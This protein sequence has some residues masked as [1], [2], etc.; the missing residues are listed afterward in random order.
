[1]VGGFVIY[2][3]LFF[4][5]LLYFLNYIVY[6]SFWQNSETIQKC[7]LNIDKWKSTADL[8]S[9]NLSSA[10]KI[11]M[12]HYLLKRGDKP[13]RL[14]DNLYKGDAFC[15]FLFAFLHIKPFLK[16]KKILLEAE[17]NICSLGSK[18]FP[19]IKGTFSH[20]ENMPMYF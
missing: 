13:C 18:V 20:H 3:H 1:M 12:V 14:S 11:R 6:Y 9:Q 7:A 4:P 16:K 17:K 5:M 8:I 15:K 2:S 10:I 19:F